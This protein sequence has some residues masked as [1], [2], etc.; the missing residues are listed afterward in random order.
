MYILMTLI[1]LS[2]GLAWGL[3][4]FHSKRKTPHRS[5]P[6]WTDL[7]NELKEIAPTFENREHL[8]HYLTGVNEQVKNYETDYSFLVAFYSAIREIKE[9]LKC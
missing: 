8:D 3:I 7:V 9:A 5:N 2:I 4:F 1:V 6:V